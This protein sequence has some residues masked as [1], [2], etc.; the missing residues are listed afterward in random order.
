[1]KFFCGD[2]MNFNP[3]IYEDKMEISSQKT[4]IFCFYDDF[5][6]KIQNTSYSRKISGDSL[7]GI[8]IEATVLYIKNQ[9]NYYKIV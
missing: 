2:T 7:F 5:S 8:P 6:V 1:M 4:N 9:N 3:K